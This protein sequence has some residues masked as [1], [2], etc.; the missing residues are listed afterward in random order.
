MC[1]R[2]YLRHALGLGWTTGGRWQRMEQN[3]SVNAEHS[4]VLFWGDWCNA[5]GRLTWR[6]NKH[7]MWSSC[8]LHVAPIQRPLANHRPSWNKNLTSQHKSCG[9]PTRASQIQKEGGSEKSNYQ[10]SQWWVWM[11]QVITV[12]LVIWVSD[13]V[14]LSSVTDNTTTE[15]PE[16]SVPIL[17][18]Y[19]MLMYVF[20]PCGPLSSLTSLH[21]TANEARTT[22]QHQLF[23]LSDVDTRPTSTTARSIT[24]L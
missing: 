5:V 7:F 4:D 2:H 8:I 1:K 13:S 22:Q 17:H 12:W 6:L 3:D 11:V 21:H 16:M 24:C 10:I 14:A 20:P 9:V 23:P 19:V 18:L 15:I